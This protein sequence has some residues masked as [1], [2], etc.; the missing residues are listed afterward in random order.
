MGGVGDA[1]GLAVAVVAVELEA[2]PTVDTVAVTAVARE[3]W[4]PS[5]LL[6]LFI[7]SL[8]ARYLYCKYD[9]CCM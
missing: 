3:D 5:E 9:V 4:V 6:V 2:V 1:S 7:D 8:S